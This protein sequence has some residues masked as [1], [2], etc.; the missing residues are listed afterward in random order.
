L[1]GKKKKNLGYEKKDSFAKILGWELGR[2]VVKCTFEKMKI[3]TY[4]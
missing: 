1:L 2:D 4:F 3:K